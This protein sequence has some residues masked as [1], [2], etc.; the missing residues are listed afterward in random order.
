[1]AKNKLRRN[2]FTLIELIIVVGIMTFL[3]GLMLATYNSY[4]ESKTLDQ[5]ASGIVDLL[6]QA[7]NKAA[8]GD[9]VGYSD[10]SGS[11]GG[12]NIYIN[13]V[14]AASYTLNL[15][16][17]STHIIQTTNLPYKTSIGDWILATVTVG[18]NPIVFGPLNT[19]IAAS[20]TIQLKDKR[21]SLNNCL[22]ITVTVPGII[23]QGTKFS[24]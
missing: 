14:N 19:P 10:C 17:T 9:T 20:T 18:N 1:M 24:C 11:F 12:Y 13:Q 16:C 8:A 23:N 22:L 5:T 15:L 7:R 4:T 2:G 21:I 3:S 6:T